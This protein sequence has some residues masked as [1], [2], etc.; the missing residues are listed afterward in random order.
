MTFSS[1]I[2]GKLTTL[3]V[4]FT[5]RRPVLFI[6]STVVVMRNICKTQVYGLLYKFRS[7]TL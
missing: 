4:P 2:M 5:L 1:S 7:Q 6:G 3:V